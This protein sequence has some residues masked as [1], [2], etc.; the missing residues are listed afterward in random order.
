MLGEVLEAAGN[1]PPVLV[2]AM[3]GDNTDFFVAPNVELLVSP[4]LQTHILT[5][6]AL[7]CELHW[8]LDE[9]FG[10]S[11]AEIALRRPTEAGCAD[12]AGATFT[13]MQAALADQG[14]ILLG[15]LRANNELELNPSPKDVP[16]S[17]ADDDQLVVL[18]VV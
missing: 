7:R 13:A 12:I 5:Q 11:G 17:L 2:E 6:V 16:L 3:A 10:A 15:V 4:D 9:L 14:E 18:D 1:A 8:V